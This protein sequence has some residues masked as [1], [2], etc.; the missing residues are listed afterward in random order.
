M[1]RSSCPRIVL[2]VAVAL[3]GFSAQAGSDGGGYRIHPDALSA[4]ASGELL[5]LD[6]TRGLFRFSPETGASVPVARFGLFAA[7]DLWSA[8]ISGTES[9]FVTLRSEDRS[10]LRRID[11]ASKKTEAWRLPIWRGNLAGV[12]V[13]PQGKLAYVAGGRS[14]EIYKID[15][16]NPSSIGS[17]F[18]R[19]QN[20]ANLGPLA[21]DR[22]RMRLLVAD[23]ER[24]ALFGVDLATGRARLIT[25][26]AGEAS[27]L[28]V[29]ART[30]ELLIAD[31]LSKKI[32][33]LALGSE[34]SKPVELIRLKDFRSPLGLALGPGGAIWVGDEMAGA[35]FLLDQKGHLL[36][37]F[38]L[39]ST[40]TR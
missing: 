4:L 8:T 15:L 9:A 38:Q 30:D 39:S 24:G 36:R 17:S 10:E 12:A 5:V 25:T 14:G 21:L 6:K 1:C 29:N 37:T 3:I 35:L 11:L 16:G 31:S 34:A 2:L 26:F 13:D 18:A 19:V 7:I 32:W 40:A 28:V 33:K 23:Y 22:K 27:A 20:G